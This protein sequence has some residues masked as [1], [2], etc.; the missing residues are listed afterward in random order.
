M[1][2]NYSK[3]I[4]KIT[5][6]YVD[7]HTHC[8]Q[9]W[10]VSTVMTILNT[11]I[12]FWYGHTCDQSTRIPKIVAFQGHGFGCQAFWKYKKMREVKQTHYKKI[13]VM[14]A[15][16]SKNW[17]TWGLGQIEVSAKEEW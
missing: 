7:E 13:F 10:Y 17:Q 5:E 9:N 6:H 11:E 3:N 2:K 16:N 12:L 4:V 8:Y 1:K 14:L 15:Q